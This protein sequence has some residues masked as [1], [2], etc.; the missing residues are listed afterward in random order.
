MAK[1]TFG[2]NATVGVPDPSLDVAELRD[3]V[4]NVVLIPGTKGVR[5]VPPGTEV[6]MD[7]LDG[8]RIGKV[9]GLWNAVAAPVNGPVTRAV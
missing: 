5:Y 8:A 3:S 9:F 7:E 2:F 4:T 6:Q 1:K